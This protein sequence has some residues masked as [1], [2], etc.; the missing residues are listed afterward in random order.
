MKRLVAALLGRRR[1]RVRSVPS[2]EKFAS[3]RAIGSANDAFLNTLAILSERHHQGGLL[4]MGTVVS[5]YESLSSPVETMVRELTKMSGGQYD[6]LLTRYEAIHREIEME[7]LKTRAIEDGPLI[8][9]PEGEEAI[10]S[11]VVG[12]K[13]ARLAAMLRSALC[14]VPPFFVVSVYGYRAFMEATGVQELAQKVLWSAD[15]SNPK[16]LQA[17]CETLRRATLNAL[18]PRPLA[19][20]LWE[21]VLKLTQ[22]M[23]PSPGLAVRSSAVVEDSSASFAG[24]FDS[25]LNVRGDVVLEAYKQVVASKYRPETVQYALAS[26]F[27]DQDVEMPVLI[28]AMIEPAASGVAYSR[29]PENPEQSLVTAVRGLAQPIVDGRLTPDRFRMARADPQEAVEVAP[30]GQ[31]TYMQC[32]PVGGTV[33]APLQPVDGRDASLSDDAARMVARTSWALERQFRAPQDVEWV[34]DKSGTLFIVQS[35]PIGPTPSGHQPD[36][37]SVHGYRILLRGAL[38]ASPGAACG[39]V[40]HRLDATSGEDVPRGVVLVVP[41]T[42]PRL[43]GLIRRVAAIVSVGASPTGH[44]ATVARECGVPCLVGVEQAFQVLSPGRVVTVDGWEGTVYEG[45]VHELLPV[46]G[47]GQ[48]RRT[49]ADPLREMVERLLARVSPLTLTDPDSPEFVAEKCQTLHDVARFVHQR[50]MAE[51]FEID[52]L[53]RHERSCAKRLV[54]RVPMEVLV[55]DLGGGLADADSRAVSQDQIVSVPLLALMEGITDPR[56]RWTGPVGFDLKGFMS[57]VLRSTAD[58]QRYGEAAFAL[59]AHDFVHFSSRLAYHFATVEA[60]CGESLNENYARFL[61]FGG[62]AGAERREWRAHFLATILRYNRF[63]VTQVG[64]R[65]EAILPKRRAS[66]IEEALVMLGRLMVSA[67]QLDMFMDSQ[68]AAETF[69]ESF[70]AGDYGFQLVRRGTPSETA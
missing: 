7:V 58:D 19:S 70:L 33:E 17:A 45:E 35:R 2:S 61:F 59:C 51:M 9:W 62:A 27:L 57:V 1:R 64:D 8:V 40:Y 4:P 36:R 53:T 69:A 10:R 44:L 52:G 14:Q 56:L 15:A 22:M 21:A 28:M 6:L 34:I 37:R 20:A 11:Q 48:A 46:F 32:H 47:N 30:G 41:Y 16:S 18:V 23:P 29:E 42:P 67:R 68:T 50:S 31:R 49:E 55:L 25:L 12:P 54:W 5:T 13:S 24:Q 65:V 26:G 3:F 39:P 60:T 66:A 38:S 43:A 63:R